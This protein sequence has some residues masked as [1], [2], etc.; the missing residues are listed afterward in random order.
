MLE[1]WLP[2]ELP[3]GD[4]GPFSATDVATFHDLWEAAYIVLVRCMAHRN[5]LGWAS[6]GKR[7]LT[8]KSQSIYHGIADEHYLRTGCRPKR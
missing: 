6:V 8:L 4:M 2:G 5:A 7:Y 3:G 1:F